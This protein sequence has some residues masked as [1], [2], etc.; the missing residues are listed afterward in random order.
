[1]P[2]LVLMGLGLALMLWWVV[3]NRRH[4]QRRD[5]QTADWDEQAERPDLWTS[6]ATCVHCGERGGLLQ[7]AG[8]AVEFECLSCG[9]RH[10]RQDRA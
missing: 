4:A 5:G 6:S 1:M 2:G 7:L 3:I 10:T 8:D 9:K